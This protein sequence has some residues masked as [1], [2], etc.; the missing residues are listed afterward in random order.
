MD[1]DSITTLIAVCAM[2]ATSTWWLGTLL[3]RIDKRLTELERGQWTQMDMR[4]WVRQ[5]REE[6]IE[7]DVPSVSDVIDVHHPT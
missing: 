4:S 2:I 5:L 3:H 6:N 7:L 1:S